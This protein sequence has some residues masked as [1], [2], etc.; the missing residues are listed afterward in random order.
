MHSHAAISQPELERDLGKEFD[1]VTLYRTLSSF[2][3]AGLLHK[4]PDDEGLA[5]YALCSG[6][7]S[8]SHSHEHVHF[9]CTACGN[10]LCIDSVKVPR[11]AAPEGYVFEEMSFLVQGLCPACNKK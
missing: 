6:C 1:R 9:K 3:E 2:V 10:T 7:N 8:N 11:I 5:R 4:V